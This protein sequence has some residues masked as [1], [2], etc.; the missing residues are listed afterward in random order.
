MKIEF[1]ETASQELA[2]IVQY[3]NTQAE[4]LGFEFAG[5]VR[6][7]LARISQWPEAWA[8]IAKR[9]RRC[10]TVRFPYSVLYQVRDNLILV[11]AVM[12]SRRHPDAWRS[13][14]ESEH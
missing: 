10:R 4:G 8:L 7:T 9:T 11:V 5:E 1:L 2:E 13:R 6:R 14:L 12:H 3:Y